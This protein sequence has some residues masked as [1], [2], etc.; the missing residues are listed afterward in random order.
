V[1][2]NQKKILKIDFLTDFGTKKS[3]F[4]VF[5]VNFLIQKK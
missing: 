4:H 1:D 3:E 5:F 2:Y